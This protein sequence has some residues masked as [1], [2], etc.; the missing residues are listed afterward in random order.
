MKRVWAMHLQPAAWPQ[1]VPR[2]ARLD[3]SSRVVVDCGCTAP[4]SGVQ[5]PP[6]APA[7]NENPTGMRLGQNVT[8][9]AHQVRLCTAWLIDGCRCRIVLSLFG[10]AALGVSAPGGVGLWLGACIV[11]RAALL[12][13]CVQICV[14]LP[15]GGQAEACLHA[16]RSGAA[17][18]KVAEGV[19][20]Q[21]LKSGARQ[22]L[23]QSNSSMHMRGRW[24]VCFALHTRFQ[25]VCAS[26]TQC[27]GCISRHVAHSPVCFSVSCVV[28]LATSR[29]CVSV[30]CSS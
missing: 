5:L 7:H 6:A 18:C 14:W 16:G 21:P 1:Q 8:D 4:S 23:S 13:V 3:A 30:Y 25:A 17:Q 27:A 26:R 29:P 20:Q 11:G 19:F 10:L 24:G 2:L 22:S 15:L 12:S 28:C 9:N